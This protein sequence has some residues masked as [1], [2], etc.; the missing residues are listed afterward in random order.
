MTGDDRLDAA[1]RRLRED[2]LAAAPERVAELWTSYARVQNG[3]IPALEGFRTLVHRL[4]GTGGS[5]GLPRVTE[6]ARMADLDCRA[7][8]EAGGVVTPDDL[9]RLR[10]LVQDIADAF[11]DASTP[12]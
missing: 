3:G 7:L 9:L 4:A 12:E 5:Y 2:Y 11:H 6:R 8:L 10:K 1:L